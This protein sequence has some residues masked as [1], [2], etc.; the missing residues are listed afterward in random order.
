MYFSF[1]AVSEDTMCV[2]FARMGTDEERIVA[3]TLKEMSDIDMGSPLHTLIVCGDL[4]VME[5]EV[6]DIFSNKK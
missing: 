6:L 2:G 3:C 1:S 5:K 4:H